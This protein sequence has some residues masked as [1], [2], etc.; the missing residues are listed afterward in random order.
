MI[1]KLVVF[2]VIGLLICSGCFTFGLFFASAKLRN[3]EDVKN[4]CDKHLYRVKIRYG[5]Y[6]G[7]I[8]EITFL[9]PNEYVAISKALKMPFRY[10]KIEYPVYSIVSVNKL[11][12]L[13]D[14]YYA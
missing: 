9:A 2:M 6:G 4:A 8:K 13:E 12:T 7:F 14:E 5:K 1:I 3:S 10:D 11:D